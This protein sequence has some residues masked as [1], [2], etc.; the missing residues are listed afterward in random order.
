MRLYIGS[1]KPAVLSLLLT[2][3]RRVKGG[4]DL[5]DENSRWKVPKRQTAIVFA[6]PIV[7]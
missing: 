2:L 1:R 6:C 3:D 5:D 4:K 7:A